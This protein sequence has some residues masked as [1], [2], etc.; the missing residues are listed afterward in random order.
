MTAIR[1]NDQLYNGSQYSRLSAQ[2]CKKL[3]NASLEI[4]ARTGAQPY[5]Q[6]AIDLMKKAGAHV[7]EGN[8]VRVPAGLVEKHSPPCPSG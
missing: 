1:L 8:R 7:S 4:L 2:Q 5:D 6:E 3:H